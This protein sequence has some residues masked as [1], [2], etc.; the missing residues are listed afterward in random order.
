MK[1]LIV[2]N[3]FAPD[4]CGGAAQFTDLAKGLLQRGHEVE[5]FTAFPYYPEWVKKSDYGFFALKPER[6]DGVNVV[7]HGLYVPGN[8]SRLVPRL[9]YELSFAVVLFRSLFRGS[10]S[11]VTIVF[12]PLLGA[13]IFAV[14]RKLLRR[15]LLW[16]N[17]QD[18]PTDASIAAGISKPGVFQS[19]A[20]SFQRWLFRRGNA[21]STISN[22]M[23]SR[24]EELIGPDRTIDVCSNWLIS[25]YKPLKNDEKVFVADASK[26]T[27]DLLYC[28]NIGHKQGLLEFCSALHETEI[29][30]RFQIRG[31]GAAMDKLRQW[32]NE[33]SDRR[34]ELK[35]FLDDQE[36]VSA[37]AAT[38]LFVLTEKPGSGFS[39]IPSKLIPAISIGTPLLV[40]SDATSPLGQETIEHRL[41]LHCSWEDIDRLPCR[42][43]ELSH[44][45]M[46]TFSANCLSRAVYYT[47]EAAL[48]R[49]ET[50]L[51]RLH[52]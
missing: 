6:V 25:E 7:R 10:R 8:P 41:G 16:I 32:I 26:K 39:F 14:V 31:D 51:N 47:R 38:D 24:L 17:I 34:F 50:V 5:V 30:F 49:Y 19:I 12:C 45:K 36:F 29:D 9:C 22:A 15:E 1:I 23:Q 46:Q 11:D 37:I 43:S 20:Q 27:I 4:F 28:G 21:I 2:S 40:I 33:K 13:V 52:G 44:L 42:V 3:L 35:G 18:I 48:D